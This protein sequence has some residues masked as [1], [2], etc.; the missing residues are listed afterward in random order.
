MDAY[1]FMH[2]FCMVKKEI[3]ETKKGTN[4]YHLLRM[5]SLYATI[6]ADLASASQG[7]S[8]SH[9]TGVVELVYYCIAQG[10]V[11]CNWNHTIL[12]QL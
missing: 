8:G 9:E 11:H 6:D 4:L 5:Q 12:Q 2:P 3:E 10:L 1:I 7:F